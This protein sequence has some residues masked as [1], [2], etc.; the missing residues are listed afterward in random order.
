MNN[1]LA[2]AA[3]AAALMVSSFS[4]GLGAPA[5]TPAYITAAVGDA[6]RPQA[7]KDLDAQRHPAEMLAATGIVPGNKVVEFVPGGGYVTRLLSKVV[8]ASGHI[9]SIELS[10]FPDRFKEQ[11]KPVT[12]NPAYSNVTV[13]VQNAAELKTPEPVD[14]VWV[15][16]NYHDFKNM[17]PFNTD[18][19]AM[20]KAVF[21]A[22]KPGGLYIIN[23]YVAPAGSGVRDTQALHRIDP[24]I[25]RSEVTAAGFAFDSQSSALANPNDKH[26]ERSH[27]GDDQVF[28]KFR[29]PR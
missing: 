7:N 29:K 21:A 23:D 28:F 12:D 26:T 8:G 10:G 25:I 18:T 11:I 19:N 2:L 13:L 15:S 5:A 20:N 4:P 1:R 17:G 3:I 14:V 24:A 16:E 9:Y 22:L 27:Q 6:N